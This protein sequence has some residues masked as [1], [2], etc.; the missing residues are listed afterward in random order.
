MTTTLV[1][2]CTYLLPLRRTAID[3][4]ELW[5]L[6]DYF[7]LLARAGCEVV[8]VDGSP[9]ETFAVHHDA[10]LIRHCAPDPSYR[11]LN[12]KVNGVHTGVH[13]A[14][15]ETIIL[16]DDDIRYTTENVEQMC[17]LL[18]QY[19]VVRPQNFLRPL[20]WWARTENARIL[21]N[22]GW[23]RAGDYPGTCGFR[24]STM[25]RVDPYDGDVLFDNEEI[26]RHFLVRGC[27]VDHALGFFIRKN[28]PTLKKWMEQRPRQAYEDFMMR[29]KTIMFASFVPSLV[30]LA[31]FVD[32]HLALLFF[33]VTML[34]AVIVCAKGLWRNAAHQVFPVSTLFFAPL[35]IIERSISVYWA[36]YWRLRYGG[37][38]FGDRLLSK[39]TGVDWVQ[40][41]RVQATQLARGGRSGSPALSEQ[42]NG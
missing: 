11:W 29:T 9:A 6:A 32:R 19:E 5:E 39:G 26:I 25:L 24:R 38:P 3:T 7:K 4:R 18:E 34:V 13:L 28:A 36:L 20:Y 22:R 40:G 33:Q 27:R 21:L 23:L 1:E 42:E 16:A 14:T 37:Y 15:Y 10:W 12:G 2:K 41:G 8:V 35:W 17:R 30:L 31:A